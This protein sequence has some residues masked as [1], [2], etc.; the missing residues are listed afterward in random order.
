MRIVLA[1]VGTRGDVEPMLALADALRARGHDCVL[2]APQ[3]FAPSAARASLPFVSLGEAFAVLERGERNEFRVVRAFL[4]TLP[5]L[6]DGMQRATE[7]ADVIVGAM[8]CLAGPSLA[9]QRGIPWVYAGFSPHYLRSELMVP[10]GIPV[11]SL[12]RWA[13]RAFNSVQHLVVPTLLRRWSQT[14]VRLGFGR[15]ADLFGHMAL[16]GE[17]LLAYDEELLPT[18]TDAVGRL[19]QVGVMRRLDVGGPLEPAL[20]RFLDAGAPPVYIGFGSMTHRDPARLMREVLDGVKRA[21]TRAVVN[22]GW[23]G[24]NAPDLPPTVHLVTSA[25]H[26]LLFPRC[27]GV[28]HHGGAGTLHAAALA[29]VPQAIVHHWADQIH[30]GWRIEDLGLGPAPTTI[31]RFSTRWLAETLRRFESDAPM[32]SRARAFG[33]KL[34]LRGGGATRAAAVVERAVAEYRGP[35]SR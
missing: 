18:P 2:A 21:G 16:R 3:S 15:P 14:E 19:N 12:P 34:R 4:K 1:P 6:Y 22:A 23:S 5:E 27:L 33:E 30:H 35:P 31:T 10:G 8:M 17:L 29:G 28:V 26:D 25:P 20:E 32:R 7:G 11:R 9:R 13:L 24:L